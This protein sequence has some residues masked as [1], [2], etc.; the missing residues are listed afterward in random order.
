MKSIVLHLIFAITSIVF[1]GITY[2]QYSSPE[3]ATYDSV[4]SRYFV[5]NTSSRIIS[6]RD[7]QGNVDFVNVGA[8]YM[9][10]RFM[11]EEFTSA[12]AQRCAVTIFQTLQKL[13]QIAGSSFLNDLAIDASGMIYVSDFTARRIYKVNSANQD[14]WT[15]VASTTNTP[16]GVYVDAPRNRLLVCCWGSSAP[17]RAVSFADSSIATL[18]ITPYSN[19]DGIT[20]DR[21]DNVYVSTWGIQSVVKYDI[22]FSQAPV[23]VTGGLSNPADI[24]VNKSKDTLEI[25]NAGNNTVTFANIGTLSGILTS[26]SET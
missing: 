13:L 12:M 24:F 16:N 7:L 19:L 6:Q 15:Y 17:I 25:P 3:S 9:E 20:L 11:A 5:S 14:Y 4:S 8:L 22:N 18:V 10:S 1:T 23:I 2:S 26:L 21:N